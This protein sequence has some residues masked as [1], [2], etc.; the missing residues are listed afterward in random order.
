MTEPDTSPPVPDI[1]TLFCTNPLGHTRDN[2]TDIIVQMRSARHLY[3]TGAPKKKG[4][5]KLT[6]KETATKKLG[7]KLDLG[8][9]GL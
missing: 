6:A 5:V 9:I 3:N 2:I 7:L 4:T 1:A 8:D